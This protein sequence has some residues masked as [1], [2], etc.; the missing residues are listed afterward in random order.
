MNMIRSFV[1]YALVSSSL[2]AAFWN[3]CTKAQTK[4][5][6]KGFTKERLQQL[7]E[8][9]KP[10]RGFTKEQLQKLHELRHPKNKKLS[11]KS[12]E[13]IRKKQN[14]LYNDW[15]Q[16][17]TGITI[18][19]LPDYDTKQ[20]K[21]KPEKNILYKELTLPYKEYIAFLDEHGLPHNNVAK[22][23]PQPVYYYYEFLKEQSALVK[24]FIDTFNDRISNPLSYT[25][26]KT[27]SSQKNQSVVSDEENNINPEAIKNHLQTEAFRHSPF[28]KKLFKKIDDM[29]IFLTEKLPSIELELLL[30]PPK[31]HID[32]KTKQ[33]IVDK[34]S[35]GL[36]Q[37]IAKDIQKFKE[38]IEKLE[39]FAKNTFSEKSEGKDAYV[40]QP[41]TAKRPPHHEEKLFQKLKKQ[42]GQEPPKTEPKKEPQQEQQQQ[43][44]QQNQNPT[45]APLN[46]QEQQMLDDIVKKVPSHQ[47]QFLQQLIPNIPDQQ[48]GQVLQTLSQFPVDQLKTEVDS[49]MKEAMKH[50]QQQQQG[51]P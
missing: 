22:S 8:L 20:A 13:E 40:Y 46:P 48:R 32:K 45:I 50:M 30:I 15:I 41:K 12:K 23:E 43:Q 47:Q 51:N 14:D 44:Q 49:L 16:K 5:S 34:P 2:Y 6:K 27:S 10:T 19:M 3:C 4:K 7:H 24:E 37:K 33:K 18:N 35:E 31:T 9:R 28:A 29:N 11:E 1:L 36:K 17:H 38:A 21:F 26:K 25:K 39:T 42:L